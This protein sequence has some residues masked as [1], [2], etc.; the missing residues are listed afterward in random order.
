[1]ANLWPNYTRLCPNMVMWTQP[2]R[3]SDKKL[4][5]RSRSFS[6]KILTN[7]HYFA[8]CALHSC[9]KNLRDIWLQII[10][11][12]LILSLK[13][14]DLYIFFLRICIQISTIF[15]LNLQHK[16]V[17]YHFLTPKNIYFWS[18]IDISKFLDNLITY[19][20]LIVYI[21]MT[22]K[23]TMNCHHL[24]LAGNGELRNENILNII[25]E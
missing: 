21:K 22:T 5:Y 7:F 18:R 8:L 2:L 9:R 1:M 10:F 12:L 17:S 20:L 11:H 3:F 13:Q 25:Y 23:P 16:V 4:H 19:R 15:M 6:P 14:K 24:W